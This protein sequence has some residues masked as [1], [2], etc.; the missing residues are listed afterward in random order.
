MQPAESGCDYRREKKVVALSPPNGSSVAQATSVQL[1]PHPLDN[2]WHNEPGRGAPT[3][4]GR[5]ESMTPASSRI[6]NQEQA[7]RY[8]IAVSELLSAYWRTPSAYLGLRPDVGPGL[9]GG[10][11][12]SES[13]IHGTCVPAAPPARQTKAGVSMA[14]GH[15]PAFL[16]EKKTPACGFASVGASPIARRSTPPSTN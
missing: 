5:L 10:R 12:S 13:M 16:C 3:G 8:S 6:T 14:G 15:W 1:P 4:A 2:E 7:G 11:A 9:V